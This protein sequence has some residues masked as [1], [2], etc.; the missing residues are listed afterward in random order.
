MAE[1]VI[2]Q[3]RLIGDRKVLAEQVSI[4]TDDRRARMG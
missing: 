3:L 1:D 4:A 2:V